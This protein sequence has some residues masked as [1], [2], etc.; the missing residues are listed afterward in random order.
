MEFTVHI[1]DNSTRYFGFFV[2]FWYFWFFFWGGFLV[3]FLRL[4]FYIFFGYILLFF[5][6]VKIV[7][8][9]FRI[10]G[11]I[12]QIYVLHGDGLPADLLI[13]SH[14]YDRY[15]Y[16]YLLSRAF[17]VAENQLIIYQYLFNMFLDL[18]GIPRM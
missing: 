6:K 10:Q 15:E 3:F 16:C 12:S 4:L 2:F 5:H 8:I 11:D 14:T 18:N 17:G 1:E 7:Y 13:V 9:I